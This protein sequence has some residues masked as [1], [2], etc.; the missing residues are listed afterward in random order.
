M[1]ACLPAG[2]LECVSDAKSIDYVKKH[3]PHYQS[4]REFY[5]RVYGPSYSVP[6]RRAQHNFMRSLAAYSIFTHLLQVARQTAI[7]L[8][9]LLLLPHSPATYLVCSPR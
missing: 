5:E 4:M 2:L 7:R 6:F 8:P 1:P 9:A 3:T